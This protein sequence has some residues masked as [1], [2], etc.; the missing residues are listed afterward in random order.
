MVLPGDGPLAVVGALLR[1]LQVGGDEG[2]QRA[3]PGHVCVGQQGEG[4]QLAPRLARQQA[5]RR[6][7][8]DDRPRGHPGG[9]GFSDALR[10]LAGPLRGGGR[11]GGRGGAG[12]KGGRGV[13]RLG[14]VGG[15]LAFE[16]VALLLE[17]LRRRAHVG[18]RASVGRAGGGGGPLGGVGVVR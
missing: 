14:G 1:P 18:G 17:A 3:A 2:P 8:H 16:G 7:R 9:L 5:V 4:A 11:R 13:G 15:E 6:P 12:V 10:G